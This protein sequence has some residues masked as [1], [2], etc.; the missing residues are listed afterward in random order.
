MSQGTT[1]ISQL[2][3]AKQQLL[4]GCTLIRQK[5]GEIKHFEKLIN[6]E[7]KIQ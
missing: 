4:G 6:Q 7:I 1:I 3:D 5:D 2:A